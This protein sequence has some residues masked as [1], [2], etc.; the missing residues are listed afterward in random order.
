ML[1]CSNL[2]SRKRGDYRTRRDRPLIRTRAWEAQMDLLADGYLAW[3]HYGPPAP[4][5]DGNYSDSHWHIV[6][7]DFFGERNGYFL[8]LF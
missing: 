5:V 3:N 6:V 2:H 1:N 8:W 4:P 7:V